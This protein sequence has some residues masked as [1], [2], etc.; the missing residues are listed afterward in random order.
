MTTPKRL[1]VDVPPKERISARD[2]KCYTNAYQRLDEDGDYYGEV[3]PNC[4]YIWEMRVAKQAL[5]CAAAVPVYGWTSKWNR[6]T[7]PVQ[8]GATFCQTH[9][10]PGRP[11]VSETLPKCAPRR[12]DRDDAVPDATLTRNLK[13]VRWEQRDQP[14]YDHVLA[15]GGRDPHL[16]IANQKIVAEVW[17]RSEE[18]LIS[19]LSNMRF[20]YQPLRARIRRRAYVHTA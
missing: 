9:G 14:A 18:D 3:P 20:A 15:G 7:R 5:G 8:P 19:H 12:R 4:T 1:W 6:C 17:P 2:F 11:P 10:G 13:R 16:D